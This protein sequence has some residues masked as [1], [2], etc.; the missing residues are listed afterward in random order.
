MKRFNELTIEQLTN[1]INHSKKLRQELEDYICDTEMAWISEKLDKV[2]SSL[3]DWSVGFYQKNYINV[4]DY[5]K[6]VYCVAESIACFGGSDRL[7]RKL[8]QCEKLIGTNLF[9]HHARELRDIYLKEELQNICDW[10]EDC[11]YEIYHGEVGEKCR[12]YLEC[13]LSS[14]DDYLFDEKNGVVYEPQKLTA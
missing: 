3:Q 13:F 7:T 4:D 2:R 5:E 6:F 1:V 11:C 9:E 8:A 10:V 12:E 14:Y